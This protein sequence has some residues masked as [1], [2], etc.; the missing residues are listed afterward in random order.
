MFM[1]K[2]K[3]VLSGIL[4]VSLI[5]SMLSPITTFA[6]DNTNSKSSVQKT[7]DALASSTQKPVTTEEATTAHSH[8]YSVVSSKDATCTTNG[9]ITYKCSCG[10][11][12]I[13]TVAATG[14]SWKTTVDKDEYGLDAISIKCTVCGEYKQ[15][16]VHNHIYTEETIQP[17]CTKAGKHTLTCVCGDVIEE[18][19]PAMGHTWVDKSN[20]SSDGTIT[21]YK[22]CSVCGEK[23]DVKIE[24]PVHTHKYSITDTVEP[25]CITNGYYVYTCKCGDSYKETIAATG[26]SW[27]TDTV[28]PTCTEEGYKITK[29]KV[30]GVLNSKVILEPS[31]TYVKGKTVAPTCTEK[32]YTEYICS[33]CN[34]VKKDNFVDANG[35]TLYVKEEPATCTKDGYYIKK[36]EDCDYVEK[37]ET[38]KALGHDLKTIKI[39]PTCT[40]SGSLKITCNRGDYSETTEIPKTNHK[41]VKTV[42]K[43][44]YTTDGYTLNKCSVCGKSYKSNIVKKLTL[45]KT[46]VKNIIRT[47]PDKV[48]ITFNSV[49][50]ATGYKLY[51]NSGKCIATS[52]KTTFAVNQKEATNT[53][54]YIIAYKK[55]N[56]KTVVDSAKTYVTVKSSV[57]TPAKVTSVSSNKIKKTNKYKVTWNKSKYATSYELNYATNSKFKNAK[58][59]KVTKGNSY[60]FNKL[61]KNKTYYVRVK[62]IRTVK[63]SSVKTNY[64]KTIKISVK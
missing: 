28:E 6:T 36:C 17:T 42:V 41:Y 40:K 19:L 7:T 29:C 4:G 3:K 26:H 63:N 25:T 54:Y 50:N 60:T 59:I 32:G 27:I 46:S 10:D 1:I 37:E 22:E 11:S 55:I 31:H 8:S 20:T 51:N 57:Y 30:C 64:S 45:N 21:T 53:K 56:N 47:S 18:D 44:T 35:H 9:S 38:I 48:S 14:H 49:K 23:T 52:N 24:K 12:Y 58:T 2:N 62:S 15:K 33:A 5:L 34:D 13:E 39:N 43:P 61:T 16:P